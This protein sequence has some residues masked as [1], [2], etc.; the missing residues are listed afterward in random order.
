MEEKGRRIDIYGEASEHDM[1]GNKN[2]NALIS[3][4]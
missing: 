4:K 2:G 1:N 3:L